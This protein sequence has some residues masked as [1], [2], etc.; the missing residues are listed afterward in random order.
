MKNFILTFDDMRKTQFDIAYPV[1]KKFGFSATFFVML[2]PEKRDADERYSM[3]ASELKELS[4]A[5][6]ELGNHT[7]HHR[8]PPDESAMDAELAAVEAHFAAHGFSRPVSF[9]YAGGPYNP[10]GAAAAR[11]HACLCARTNEPGVY[12]PASCD[13]F[14][15][16]AYPV[17]D[18]YPGIFERAFA[19][20]EESDD[21][22][23]VLIYHGLPDPYAPASTEPD[24]FRA[25]M[26]FLHA[27]RCRCHSLAGFVRSHL[28]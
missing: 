1:L 21:S 8:N 12:R 6:F 16:P 2:F 27:H 9:A 23:V 11:K 14:H 25:Q 20:A 19:A 17:A 13:L 18:K 28:R 3:T 4:D 26:E 24:A 22:A 7:A 15:I 10:A 5:G